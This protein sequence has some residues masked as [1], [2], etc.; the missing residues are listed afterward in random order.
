MSTEEIRTFKSFRQH[1]DHGFL[2]WSVTLNF[3]SYRIYSSE[4]PGRSFNFEFSK[5]EELIRKRRSSEG[6][7]HQ[8]YQ[9]DIKILSTCLLNQ[10]IRA[11][12]I[13]KE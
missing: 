4:R 12:I 2:L 11:V 7:A 9:R 6:D 8:I 13:T 1:M 10:T 3:V 5:G